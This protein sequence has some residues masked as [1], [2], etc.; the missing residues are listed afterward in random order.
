MAANETQGRLEALM[1]E[2]QIN[3]ARVLALQFAA[4]HGG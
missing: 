4:E 3:M 2:E 1:T